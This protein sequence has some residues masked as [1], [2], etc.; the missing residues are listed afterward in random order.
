MAATG[1]L[2][3][4]TT[5]PSYHRIVSP[6]LTIPTDPQLP[7]PVG[8]LAC[9]RKHLPSPASHPPTL[10]ITPSRRPIPPRARDYH[11]KLHDLQISTPT[12]KC[13]EEQEGGGQ[14]SDIGIITTAEGKT[15]DI[16]QVKRHGG[17]AVH[18][19]RVQNSDS[20]AQYFSQGAKVTVALGNDGVNR[21]YDHMSMHTSQHLLSAIL[22]TRLNLPTLS[23]SLTTY[24]APCYVE[25][26]R[27]MS[28]EEITA[29][30]DEA[31]RLVF[32]GRKVHVEVEEL[33]REQESDVPKHE[34]GRA[35]GKTLPADYTG[36]VKRVVVIDGVD[37]NPC[38]GTHLPSLHNL[39]L[40]LIPQTEALSRSSTTSARLYFLSGPRLIAHLTSSHSLLANTAAILSCGAP[41]VPDRVGQ[42]VDERKKAEKRVEDLELELAKSVAEDILTEACDQ[43]EERLFVKHLHRTDDAANAL[44]FL[45]SVSFSFS[46]TVT[47]KLPYLLVMTS[48]PS[49]QT[50]SSTSV[51][52]VSGSDE[53]KVKTAGERLKTE[54]GVK[55]GGRG[56]RWSGKFIGVW[57]EGR[58]DAAIEDILRALVNE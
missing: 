33:N 47:E 38:C 2:L 58:E 26:P 12:A 23:W 49:S 25:L 37:R 8:L 41:L 27:S 3:L 36:G 56:P 10:L 14:P 29:I 44:G 55:G 28:I 32:E 6:T 48:S 39:Q 4:P 24:P 30:Q 54:I 43:S 31:N 15:W 18:Y 11:H 34:S 13:E 50:T 40:F 35:V 46:N 45:S 7:I 19:I 42:V 9:Q 5:P 21:R 22:E 17:H 1:L 51:V 52:L 57:K 16:T 53:Q 20:D